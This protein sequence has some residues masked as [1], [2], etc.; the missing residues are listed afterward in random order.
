V[1]KG[2]IGLP[3]VLTAKTWG[4]YDVLFKG[5]EFEFQRPYGEYIMQNV[6]FKI[7]YPAEFHAQTAVE[8]AHILHQKLKDMGK[9]AT[10]IK[11]VVIRTQEAAIRIID[12]QG[13]LHNFADR[14]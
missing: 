12:K 1:Q 8:A 6:L 7:S 3:S 13:P 5:R 9:S 11:S 14:E 10:D 2:E 4:F